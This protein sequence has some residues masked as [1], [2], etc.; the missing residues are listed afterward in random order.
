MEPFSILVNDHTYEVTP[1]V[2]G[3]TVSLQIETGNSKV[4]FELDEEDQLRAITSGDP[5]DQATIEAFADAII[6]HFAK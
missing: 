4:V 1:Y 3:Y 2:K 5:V 6:R